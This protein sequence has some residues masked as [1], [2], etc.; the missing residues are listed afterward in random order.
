M[1]P[2]TADQGF[3]FA[4]G[5]SSVHAFQNDVSQNT[6]NLGDYAKFKADFIKEGFNEAP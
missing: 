6:T 3:K 4:I 5:L 2:L 1:T